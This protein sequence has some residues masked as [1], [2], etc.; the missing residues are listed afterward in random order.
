M[1]LVS[2][3]SCSSLQKPHLL[4]L[5]YHLAPLISFYRS[6]TSSSRDT[7]LLCM[8]QETNCD[9]RFGDKSISSHRHDIQTTARGIRHILR[10]LTRRQSTAATTSVK[11]FVRN[12]KSLDHTTPYIES[13]LRVHCPIKSLHPDIFAM[14]LVLTTCITK[15]RTR[16]ACM[17]HCPLPEAPATFFI[18][19]DI[20]DVRVTQCVMVVLLF[21]AFFLC[22]DCNPKA[23]QLIY[24]ECSGR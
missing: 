8:P 14:I 11:R 16:L 1:R 23:A 3:N 13:F 24:T 7:T 19:L 20:H 17:K 4:S 21:D 18:N 22:Y 5:Q 9:D 10:R 2:R 12:Q 15:I 6:V